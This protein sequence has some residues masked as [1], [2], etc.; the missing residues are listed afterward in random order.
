MRYIP[1]S[2][3]KK[4]PIMKTMKEHGG[5]TKL[6]FAI[7]VVS[8]LLSVTVSLVSLNMVATHDREQ[9]SRV[10]A[11]EIY[12]MLKSE[13]EEPAVVAKT[14][15]NDY[16]LRQVLEAEATLSEADSAALFRDYLSGIVKGLGYQ[17]AFVVSDGSHRYY[18][19]GRAHV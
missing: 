12:D 3:K 17:S 4:A 9:I 14:M 5:I 18:K 16:F 15:A 7:I 8:F 10:L 2:R 19:I 1:V 13:M 6:T 11:A